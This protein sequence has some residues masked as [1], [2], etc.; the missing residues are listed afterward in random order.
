LVVEAR[1]QKVEFEPKCCMSLPLVFQIHAKDKMATSNIQFHDQF[2]PIIHVCSCKIN[3]LSRLN[4][5][6]SIT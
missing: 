6:N 5:E 4:D 1:V 3:F 2:L